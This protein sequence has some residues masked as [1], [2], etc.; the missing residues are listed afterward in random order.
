MSAKKYYLVLDV[1]TANSTDD[2]LVYDLGYVVCDKKGNIYEADS[3]I[4][5]GSRTDAVCLLR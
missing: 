5:Q 3:F 4:V 1:E 2:A